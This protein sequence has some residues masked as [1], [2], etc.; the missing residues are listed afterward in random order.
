MSV[1]AET[2]RSKLKYDGASRSREDSKLREHVESHGE[3]SSVSPRRKITRSFHAWRHWVTTR[4]LVR[5][6]PPATA[7]SCK[8]LTEWYLLAHTDRTRAE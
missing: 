7:L 6:E 8:T 5:E 4:A 3:K 2:L 1:T